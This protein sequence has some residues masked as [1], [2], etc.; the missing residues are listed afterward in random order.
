MKE[1]NKPQSAAQ[2]DLINKNNAIIIIIV[3]IFIFLHVTS[4]TVGTIVT[5]TM[6]Q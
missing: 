5:C 3:I 1:H 6:R 4:R 2:G